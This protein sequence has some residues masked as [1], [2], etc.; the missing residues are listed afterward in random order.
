MKK[1]FCFKI[2]L[3]LTKFV[4]KAASPVACKASGKIGQNL[5]G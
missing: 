4:D 2:K 5:K 1:K 3:I